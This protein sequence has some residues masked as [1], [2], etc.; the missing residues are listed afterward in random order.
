MVQR[1]RIGAVAA[2]RHASQVNALWITVE[3]MHAGLQRS[4]GHPGGL[5]LPGLALRRLR[6]HHQGREIGRVGAHVGSQAGLHLLLAVLAAFTRA[7]QEKDHRYAC[8]GRV[9]RSAIGGLAGRHEDLVT[10]HA[11]IHGDLALEELA[12]G[13]GRVHSDRG[14]PGG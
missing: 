1:E 5:A 11:A 13:G 4:Q 3:L 2:T 14:A 6:E 10:V 9:V 8:A 12:A 7:V